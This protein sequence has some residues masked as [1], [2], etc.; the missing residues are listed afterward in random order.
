MYSDCFTCLFVCLFVHHRFLDRSII[1]PL[2]HTN[3]KRK[4]VLHGGLC[5]SVVV[6]AMNTWARFDPEAPPRG[7]L[8]KKYDASTKH[9]EWLGGLYAASLYFGLHSVLEHAPHAKSLL[10]FSYG[11]G[12]TAT[13]MK[14]TVH[15]LPEGFEPL[16]PEIKARQ[17][18]TYEQ[19]SVLAE[20][21]AQ[22]KCV[23]DQAMPP[24]PS[25]P[26]RKSPDQCTITRFPAYN[27]M[28][29]YDLSR[30]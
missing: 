20:R 18:L 23:E 11:S 15:R 24:P 12:S 5:R 28:R 4:V 9:G 30:S 19:A 26:L 2:K 1:E 16:T 13:L 21:H 17:E 29:Q 6:R 7:E 14:A 22:Y 3:M 27:E 10:L 25:F 8:V